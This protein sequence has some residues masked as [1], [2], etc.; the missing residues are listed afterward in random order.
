MRKPRINSTKWNI[1]HLPKWKNQHFVEKIRTIWSS[2]ANSVL[3][4]FYRNWTRWQINTA[5]FEWSQNKNKNRFRT[6]ANVIWWLIPIIQYRYGHYNKV[7]SVMKKEK[8]FKTIFVELWHSNFLHLKVKWSSCQ[9]IIEVFRSSENKS[10]QNE[11]KNP[12]YENWKP[13]TNSLSSETT[14]TSPSGRK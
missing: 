11:K 4:I 5:K 10:G 9:I 12:F 1:W 8:Q 13:R 6:I 14:V 7:R 2:K 3:M